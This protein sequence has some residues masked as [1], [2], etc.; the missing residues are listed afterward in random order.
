[1][2]KAVI[3]ALVL[4]NCYIQ[5]GAQEFYEKYVKFPPQA[6]AVSYT[7]LTLPTKA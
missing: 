7:H 3:L 4:L 2:K 5:S 6:T 1:M